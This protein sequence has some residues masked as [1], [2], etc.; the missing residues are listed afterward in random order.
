MSDTPNVRK[1][2]RSRRG[3]CHYDLYQL[4]E[5]DSVAINF[6]DVGPAF[7]AK[8]KHDGLI[9]DLN[10]GL[11]DEQQETIRHQW[12]TTLPDLTGDPPAFEMV[13]NRLDTA[14]SQQGSS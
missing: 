2:R 1:P 6:A 8:C 3:G 12:E 7:D 4:L 10:D 13:W 5:T 14:I 11:P 9:V